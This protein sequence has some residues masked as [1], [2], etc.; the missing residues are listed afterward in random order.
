[1]PGLR[2]IRKPSRATKRAGQVNP[3]ESLRVDNMPATLAR[4]AIPEMSLSSSR[5][6]MTCHS[7]EFTIRASVLMEAL[8][9]AYAAWIAESKWD[10]ELCG[11]PQDKLAEAG[12]P[13]L[14]Q[15][16]GSPSLLELV[17]GHYLLRDFLPQCTWDGVSPIEYWLD[18]VTGCCAEDG[19]IRLS[20]ICYSK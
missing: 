11:G 15:L 20:G 10:D 16:M 12:Y 14:G 18:E 1:M 13:E 6:T 7:F 8:E 5:M 3:I 19:I 2:H 17:I 4:F 9:P